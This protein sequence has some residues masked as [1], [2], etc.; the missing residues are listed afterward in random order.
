MNMTKRLSRESGAKREWDKTQTATVP[1]LVISSGCGTA[2]ST[3]AEGRKDAW[4][5]DTFDLHVFERRSK[6]T[7]S[8]NLPHIIIREIASKSLINQRF[9]KSPS[10]GTSDRDFSEGEFPGFAGRGFHAP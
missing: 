3:A 2:E 4:K 8:K 5:D 1:I 6:Y 10:D 9:Q 7:K